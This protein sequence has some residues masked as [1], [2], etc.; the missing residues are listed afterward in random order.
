LPRRPPACLLDHL[1]RQRTN[2]PSFLMDQLIA[3]K[4]DLLD[5]EIQAMFLR[6]T[7]KYIRDV[8]NLKDYND[9][10][11]WCNKVWEK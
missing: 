8:G 7:P 2:K 6:K 3:L 10:T 11:Q 9:L 5:D 1:G 4:P